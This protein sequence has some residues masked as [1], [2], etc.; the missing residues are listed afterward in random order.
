MVKTSLTT[1]ILAAGEGTR[2][3]SSRPKVMHELAGLPLLAH[4]LKAALEAQTASLGVVIGPHHDEVRALAAKF[5]PKAILAVQKDRRGTAHAALQAESLLKKA[6]G[7][8]IIVYGDTPLLRPETFSL[9]REKLRAGAD[10][11][12][13]AFETKMPFGYGRILCKNNRVYDIREDKDASEKEKRI[14]L[15]NG[16][17]MGFRAEI[18]YGLIKSVGNKNRAK[19]FYLTET[20][21]L[22]HEKGLRVDIALIPEED[23]LGINTRAQLAQAEQVMQRR[24]REKA[25]ADGVTLAAPET[26]IFSADTIIGEDT[27]IAPY[28]VLGP[29]VKIGKGVQI[30]SF[31]HLEGVEVHDNARIGPFARLRPGSVIGE[32]VRIGNFVEINRSR[33]GEHVSANHLTYI[34]DADVGAGTNI[35]AGTITCN[36]DGAAKFKTKIGK[37][38]FIGSNA[39]LV[40]PLDIGSEV[41]IAAGSTVTKDIPAGHLVFGRVKE[42]VSLSGRG[43]QKVRANKKARTARRAKKER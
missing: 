18:A 37:D 17:V 39:T 15:V 31:T 8:L 30:M 13:G 33:L 21:A 16:G 32:G 28:V 35:G 23:T 22:A 38:V 6:K 20:V 12:I 10:V 41:L 14:T 27:V 43:A 29:G 19:E 34:G 4:V 2:M 24:L 25:M 36:F 42:Q 1:L 11:V 5:A 7:D 40:A 9:L 26:V 3:R